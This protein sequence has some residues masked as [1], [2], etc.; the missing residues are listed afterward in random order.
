MNLVVAL[1]ISCFTSG[2]MSNHFLTIPSSSESKL[3]VTGIKNIVA[4]IVMA[5][6]DNEM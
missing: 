3:E 6:Q 5:I 4:I 1:K 2:E